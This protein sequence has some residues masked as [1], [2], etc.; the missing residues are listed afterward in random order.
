[1]SYIHNI[2]NGLPYKFII[3]HAD[4]LRPY[5]LPSKTMEFYTRYDITDKINVPL[6][7]QEHEQEQVNENVNDGVLTGGSSKYNIYM[8]KYQIYKERNNRYKIAKYKNK[9]EKL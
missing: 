4:S 5:S 6:N 8:K 9:I 3:G 7:E 1:M 2:E